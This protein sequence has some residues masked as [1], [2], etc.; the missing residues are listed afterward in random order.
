MATTLKAVVARDPGYAP[1]W[2]LLAKSYS[3]PIA[4]RQFDDAVAAGS[5]EEA[6]RLVHIQYDQLEKA[7]RQAIRLDPHNALAYD[8]LGGLEAHRGNWAASEDYEKRALTLDP[9][10]PDILYSYGYVLAATGRIKQALRVQNQILAQE[11]FVPVYRSRAADLLWTMGQNDEAIKILEPAIPDGA[12]RPRLAKI[13]ATAGRYA[14]AADMLRSSSRN[15]DQ[16][17]EL[18]AQL[19]RSAPAKVSAPETLPLLQGNLSFVYLFIG[20]EGRSL[21][22]VEREID[23][24]YYGGIFRDP[25]APPSAG[26]RKTD[27]FKQFVRKARFVEYWRARGWPEYC[28]PVGADDFA[29]H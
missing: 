25:W 1:A 16:E 19:I 8:A 5:M 3:N 20:A 27:R 10:N 12:N 26:L 24:G 2:A 21:D 14:R 15:S 28:R 13:Y 11:P 18:A 29:C 6:R 7:A 22:F 4:Y 9:N 17:L 23:A